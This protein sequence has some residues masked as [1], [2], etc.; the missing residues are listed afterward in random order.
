M[1]LKKLSYKPNNFSSIDSLTNETKPF[2][3]KYIYFLKF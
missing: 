3:K 1:K 2:L